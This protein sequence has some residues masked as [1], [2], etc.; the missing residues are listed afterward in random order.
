MPGTA[1][2]T[3]VLHLFVFAR[4]S[5]GVPNLSFIRTRLAAHEPVRDDPEQADMVAAVAL[6][7][8]EPAGGSPELLFIE[9]A[10]RQGDPWSG[11]MAFPGGRH[12][13]HDAD[14]HATATR[15]T[16]EEVGVRLGEPIGRL[17]DLVG[18]ELQ[19]L[20]L[21]VAPYVYTLEERPRIRP[22]PEVNA[23]VW[24]PV[25]WILSPESVT[26][27]RFEPAEFKGRHPAF[28][29]ERYTVWGLTYR[30]T[31]NLLKVFKRSLP[32]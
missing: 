32:I 3:R 15:E 8:H 21:L 20:R 22:N 31:Q 14:L 11:Q 6:I 17:D 24:I 7:L 4:I 23:T 29:Y 1:P 5:T 16:L 19:N 28:A 9:R 10:R 13:S 2:T 30:I 12:E 27:Y 26:E 25:D 18:G